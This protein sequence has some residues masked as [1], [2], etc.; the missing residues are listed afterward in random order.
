MLKKIFILVLLLTFPFVAYSNSKSTL[1]VEA[2][3]AYVVIPDKV[4]I[5]AMI[6]AFDDELLKA[7]E[8]LLKKK[9]SILK[10]LKQF[11]IK[12]IG[13][14]HILSKGVYR[15]NYPD[16]KPTLLGYKCFT[17]L[18]IEFSDYNLVAPIVKNLNQK[19]VSSISNV[20]IGLSNEK[21]KKYD[22]LCR[23]KAVEIA[24]EKAEKLAKF[25]GKKPGKITHIRE[26]QNYNPQHVFVGMNPI[27]NEYSQLYKQNIYYQSGFDFI[28]REEVPYLSPKQTIINVKVTVTYEMSE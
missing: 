4:T 24:Q 12:T 6:D 20:L 11:D 5:I 27:Y 10:G 21:Q 16:T 9:E 17:R 25:A 14:D 18:I 15:K 2:S 1:T 26:Y 23:S 22:A 19:G 3:A 28:Q 13:E 8:E 7:E